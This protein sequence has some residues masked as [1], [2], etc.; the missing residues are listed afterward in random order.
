MRLLFTLT[1]IKGGLIKV[2]EGRIFR[3]FFGE[4]PKNV[5]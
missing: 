1:I 4:N 3:K 2:D 5:E